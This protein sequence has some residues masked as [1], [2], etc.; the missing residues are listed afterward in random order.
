[1]RSVSPVFVIL[2]TTPR[3]P[4][5]HLITCEPGRLIS[6]LNKL[7][8]LSPTAFGVLHYVYAASA[9]GGK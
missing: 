2:R 5:I 8:R 1:M 7:L 4:R 6:I 9:V 3:G